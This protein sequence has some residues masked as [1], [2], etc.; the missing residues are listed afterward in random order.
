MVDAA[1]SERASRAIRKRWDRAKA[2]ER[3]PVPSVFGEER[4]FTEEET[5]FLRA[6][7]AYRSRHHRRYL[8]AT[9]YLHVL[10]SLGYRSPP[11]TPSEGA[12]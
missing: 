9:E 5:T 4:D 7:E 2:T 8:T 1:K 12:G 11:A 10:K 3:P 6:V